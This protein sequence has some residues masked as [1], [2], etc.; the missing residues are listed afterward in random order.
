MIVGVVVIEL[1]DSSTCI[2]IYDSTV[3]FYRSW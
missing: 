2:M 1:V 3:Q